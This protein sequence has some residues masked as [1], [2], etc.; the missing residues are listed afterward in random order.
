MRLDAIFRI[1]FVIYCIEAGLLLLVA[2]WNAGI[3]DRGWTQIA[4][5]HLHS[6]LLHPFARSAVSGFGVVHLLWGLHDLH[7]W[8]FARASRPSNDT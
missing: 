1:L 4:N 3:W 5:P 8:L 6:I 7:A 2:P